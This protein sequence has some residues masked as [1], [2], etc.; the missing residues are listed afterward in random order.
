M[1]SAE[2]RTAGEEL[3]RRTRKAQKLPRTVRDR[4]TARAVARL[5]VSP[6]SEG[7]RSPLRGPSATS[8][9]TTANASYPDPATRTS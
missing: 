3:A 8:E 5:L 2:V 9:R 6:I 1:T 4:Q 7:P